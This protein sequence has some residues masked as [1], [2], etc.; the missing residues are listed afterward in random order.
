MRNVRTALLAGLCLTAG[1]G[2]SIDSLFRRTPAD[3]PPD[4]P[5]TNATAEQ[6]I[7]Y[8]NEHARQLSILNCQN[9]QTEA[10][11]AGVTQGYLV[12]RQ[13]HDFRLIGKSMMGEEVDIGSNEQEFWFWVRR[14]EPPAVYYCRYADLR[15]G[16]RLPFPIQPEYISEALGMA[17]YGPASK[18]RVER[19][20][21]TWH[22]M[23]DVTTPQG[24][25]A[26]KVTVF[27]ASTKRPPHPQV[28]EYRLERP[29]GTPICSAR[30]DEVRTDRTY[31]GIWY[32][33]RITLSCPEEKL[34]VRLTLK[35]VTVNVPVAPDRAEW[36]FTRRSLAAR[37][38]ID[39]A[40]GPD[41]A[42]AGDGRRSRGSM[43]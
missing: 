43:R 18:Y 31:T 13:P 4:P 40:R 32:P 6:L 5:Q 16:V 35:E 21:N 25:P 23:E 36:L 41:P 8:L 29:N 30:I 17:T 2:C 19:R 39:L 34:E 10:V 27:A 24:Q 33:S 7:S 28:L 22:L 14:A 12:C 9:L 26:R 3:A 42:A 11:G 20:E 15:A 38:A 37:P 1:L